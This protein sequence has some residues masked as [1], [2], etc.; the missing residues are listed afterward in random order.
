MSD[1]YASLRVSP[2]KKRTLV[3]DSDDEDVLTPKRLRVAPP[4]PPATVTRRTI[5][6]KPSATPLPSHLARL[7]TIQTALQHA[8]SHALATC[9]ISP[10]ADTGIVRNVLNHHALS[11]YSGLTT[12][13]SIDDLKR[14]CWLWEWDG[15]VLPL[16]PSS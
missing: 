5:K 1:L 8:L 15:K 13:F 9:A 3:V 10:T 16:P 12:K 6:P 11:S 2:Q 7:Y 14:L 4:T